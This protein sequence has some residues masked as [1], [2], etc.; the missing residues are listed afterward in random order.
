MDEK[1]KQQRGSSV[2]TRFHC[3]RYKLFFHRVGV[4]F[5]QSTP[6]GRYS[7]VD[8]AL[9]FMED[10]DA[11]SPL[12]P[13]APGFGVTDSHMARLLSA[14]AEAFDV[15]S[16]SSNFRHWEP[17]SVESLQTALPQYEITSLIARGG[18]GAVYKGTQ[19]LLKRP[20][21]IKVLPPE[22]DDADLNFS[23]RFKLEA[24]SMAR[25]SH[26]NIV[27][28][29]EAGE[30]PAGLLYFIMEF[31]EGTDLEQMIQA[32]GR[33]DPVEALTIT[34]S[35]CLA[36]TFAHDA[37]IIHRD[38]KPSNIMLDAKGQVKVADFGL[39]KA[40]DPDTS[41]LT[42]SGFVLGTPNYTAPESR[43]SS[44][45]IDARADLYS[46]GVMLYQM[47]TGQLPFGR[48]AAPSKLVPGLDTHFDNL[49]DRCL[50]TNRDQ[51]YPTARQLHQDLS[52][53]L[54]R[55]QRKRDR[56]LPNARKTTA[57]VTMTTILIASGITA[58]WWVKGHSSATP[59][60]TPAAV[61]KEEGWYRTFPVGKWALV[62]ASLADSDNY[63]IS[64][65]G[66]Q[67]LPKWVAFTPANARGTNWAV[68]ATF[69]GDHI[70]R[71][72]E[73]LLREDGT[74]AG[75]PIFLW[76]PSP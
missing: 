16:S 45:Q 54:S 32:Q 69:K 41:N 21:A 71:V 14:G 60:Q 6:L 46:T 75:G 67:R 13:L 53:L 5:L 10:P 48:F 42:F 52:A 38:I 70:D 56:H 58:F 34:A 73:I 7:S 9:S 49:V 68:R 11:T 28:V 17:P 37:N 12:P 27:A 20:V 40:P 55:L 66:W 72:P 4:L 24:R 33:L 19:S 22:M 26:P 8:R 25:L 39:A 43:Q 3:Q 74:K 18:M 50:Q 30:T 76:R 2:Y 62:R 65:D 36:L 1:A 64:P 35:V 47:L 57:V 63:T 15:R 61:P 44:V 59:Q 51:R 31:V 29:F 23:E